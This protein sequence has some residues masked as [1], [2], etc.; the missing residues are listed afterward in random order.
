MCRVRAYTWKLFVGG[1]LTLRNCQ[2]EVRANNSPSYLP[3][4][5]GC[6][7]S[8]PWA[9]GPR[10]ELKMW[11]SGCFLMHFEGSGLFV[12]PAMRSAVSSRVPQR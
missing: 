1:P 8:I 10:Q 3:I 6:N 7:A 2:V 5:F 11:Q 4:A 9:R 12:T